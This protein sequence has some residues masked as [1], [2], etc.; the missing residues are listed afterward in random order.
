M[1]RSAVRNAVGRFALGVLVASAPAFAPAR[2]RPRPT[3]Q[4]GACAPCAADTIRRLERL[5]HAG[6]LTPRAWCRL[7][8]CYRA[9]GTI[10]G[11]LLARRT[12]ER[13]LA[14]YPDD[15]DV[16]S[17]LAATLLEQDLRPDARR[18][19]RSVLE[20]DSTHCEARAALARIAFE[21]WRRVNAYTDDLARAELLLERALRC[22]PDDLESAHRLLV[23]A[24]VLGHAERL[25]RRL[26]E[27][28]RR[29]PNDP[30]VLLMRATRAWEHGAADSATALYRRA[31]A[32]LPDSERAA[33]DLDE[34]VLTYDEQ[35]RRDLPSQRQRDAWDRAW[36]IRADP[37]PT[38]EVNEPW[39]EFAHRV[40]Q[41]DVF[42]ASPW[43]RRR[44]WWTERGEAWIRIGPPA[45][46]RRAMTPGLQSG[47]EERWFYRAGDS[48]FDLVF[49]DTRLSGDLR[50]PMG[51]GESLARLRRTPM[52]PP[53]AGRA[54]ALPL[55]CDIVGFR[56][57]TLGAEGIVAMRVDARAL[58]ASR[59]HA[60][61]I[62]WRMSF[63]D[64]EWRR[65]RTL[66]DSIPASRVAALDHTGEAT[67]VTL[68]QRFRAPSSRW[69]VAVCLDVDG[70]AARGVVRTD[71]DWR[72]FGENGPVLSDPLL[73]AAPGSPG[74]R[75]RRGARSFVPDPAHVVHA[76]EP[77]RVYVEIYDLGVRAGRTDYSIAWSIRPRRAPRGFVARWGERIARAIARRAEPPVVEQ[78]FERTGTRRD[79]AEWVNIDVSALDAGPWTIR[80][81]V[82]DRVRGVR[83]HV[84]TD[85]EIVG[86]E[87]R[88]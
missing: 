28:A 86:D 47:R 36:W 57:G 52:R 33:F 67:A 48:V 76:G 7:A 38:T 44:G 59:S 87:T 17:A 26:A 16:R 45:A 11:R 32:A 1:G 6:R 51:D 53:R 2:E 22:N 14:R 84:E 34:R 58:L 18:L 72:R 74:E 73:F 19:F 61:A 4:A 69:P 85:F 39:L 63:F 40:H 70:G 37:D 56:H 79:E 54:A 49:V 55:G 15:P 21:A 5:R 62:V 35:N 23:A 25:D 43:A 31:I 29:W 64:D 46:V 78:S 30:D 71:I 41:A 27:F 60:P 88:R 83:R 10:R 65:E 13:A 77:L 20:L 66:V 80:A 24:Y 9:R 75:V 68:V 12:L 81:T 42:F 50:I 82:H 3:A 8:E